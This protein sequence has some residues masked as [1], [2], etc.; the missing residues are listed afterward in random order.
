MK[1]DLEAEKAPKSF[2]IRSGELTRAA[3]QLTLDLR[4]VMEPH[5]ASQLKVSNPMCLSCINDNLMLGAQK[6]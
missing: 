4:R 5:T 2:V 6:Q 3:S 1:K